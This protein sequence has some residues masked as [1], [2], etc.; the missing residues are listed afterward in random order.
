MVYTDLEHPD[1][2]MESYTY[3]YDKDSN[4]TKKQRS[5]TIH[6]KVKKESMNQ[7]I[8]PMMPWED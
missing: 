2:V 8:I 6:R 4:I 7:R 5:T 1:T 3:E